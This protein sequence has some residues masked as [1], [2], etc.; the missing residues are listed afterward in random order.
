MKLTME[1]AMA[2]AE[3]LMGKMGGGDSNAVSKMGAQPAQSTISSDVE[4]L[5]ARQTGVEPD[6]VGLSHSW[7]P[8]AG[9]ERL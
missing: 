3:R 4:A 6:S 2:R 1:E 7:T 5:D 9:P 8:S